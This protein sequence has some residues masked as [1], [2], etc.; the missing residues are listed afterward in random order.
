[1]K[2]T[3]EEL[4]ENFETNPN[5][6]LD[7]LNSS[8]YYDTLQLLKQVREATIQECQ[9]KIQIEHRIYEVDGTYKSELLGAEVLYDSSE[10]WNYFST[11]IKELNDLDK[12]SIEI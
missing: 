9:K 4:I 5:Y 1:M 3:F 10:P 7:L 12:D 6:K 11:N 8:C 2:Q